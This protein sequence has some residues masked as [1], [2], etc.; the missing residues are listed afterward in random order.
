ML[1]APVSSNKA[2]GDL[3]KRLLVLLLAGL[4]LT[5]CTA[6]A[7]QTAAAQATRAAIQNIDFDPA[8]V[9]TLQSATLTWTEYSD[10]SIIHTGALTDAE[11]LRTLEKLLSAAKQIEGIPQCFETAHQHELALVRQDGSIMTVL[12]SLDSCPTLR[13]GD[14][15]YD[16]GD[17]AHTNQAIYDLFGATIAPPE[18]SYDPAQVGTLRS[19]TLLWTESA[20]RS[21]CHSATLTDR[22]KLALLE[23]LLSGATRMENIPMCFDGPAR[24]ELNLT[25]QDGTRMTVLVSLDSCPYLR[26]GDVCFSYKRMAKQLTGKDTNEAIY[27]LFGAHIN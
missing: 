20:D 8:Q 12:V 21:T 19:A 3:M 11:S 18:V 4:L 26:E 17:A 22:N 10:R 7:E 16:F 2:G 24:H 25:R 15:C 1:S 23:K 14:T 6:P 9:G 13:E 5:A 27:D